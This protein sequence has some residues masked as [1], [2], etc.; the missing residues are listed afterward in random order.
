MHLQVSVDMMVCS[1]VIGRRL[2]RDSALVLS[3]RLEDS[4]ASS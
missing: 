2:A 3:Y 1:H 4:R